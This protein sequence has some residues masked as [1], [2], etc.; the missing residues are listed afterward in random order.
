M[1][2]QACEHIRESVY[3]I[4]GFSTISQNQVNIT[5]GTA[6]MIAP[7]ILATVAHVTHVNNEMREPVH[8]RFDVIR[9]PDVGQ[10]LEQAVF[11]A[12]DPVHDIALLKMDSPRSPAS[13][14]LAA[15]QPRRGTNWGSLGF[16][17]ASVTVEQGRRMFHLT[18]RFQGAYLSGFNHRIDESGNNVLF[19]ESDHLMYPGSS[20][21]P[22]FLTDGLVIGMQKGSLAQRA[23]QEQPDQRVA[24]SLWVPSTEIIAFAARNTVTLPS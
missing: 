11:I 19:Y 6:F 3:G 9:A 16:P 24:I 1:F 17:L 14:R 21:C 13:V 5:N 22:A 12:E 4:N 23:T 15:H 20:G 18:E 2:A 10:P 8:S 7:G